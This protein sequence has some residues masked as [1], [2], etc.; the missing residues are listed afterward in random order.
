MFLLFRGACQTDYE[1][2]IR[3]KSSVMRYTAERLKIDTSIP[4]ARAYQTFCPT[5]TRFTDLC[6]INR[7]NFDI[8]VEVRTVEGYLLESDTPLPLT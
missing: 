8:I 5:I 2:W 6:Y 7:I 4:T 1:N 3:Q